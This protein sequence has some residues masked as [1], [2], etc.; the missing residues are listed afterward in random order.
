MHRKFSVHVNGGPSGGSSLRRPRS[1]D[2][3]R[4]VRTFCKIVLKHVMVSISFALLSGAWRPERLMRPGGL[5]G[6]EALEASGR[7]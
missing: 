2:P 7:I 6:L 4:Y 1:E 3:H 5:G